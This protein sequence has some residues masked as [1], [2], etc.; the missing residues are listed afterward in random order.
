[1]GD[2]LGKLWIYFRPCWGY[3]FPGIAYPGLTPWAIRLRRTYAPQSGA[4]SVGRFCGHGGDARRQTPPAQIRTFRIVTNS[5]TSF[6]DTPSTSDIFI[7]EA[8]D[9]G[10]PLGD[11]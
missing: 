6:V 11:G 7:K 1:M 10:L 4:N 3:L 9:V 5:P 2:G 8:E